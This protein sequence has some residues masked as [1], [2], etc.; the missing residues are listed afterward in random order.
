MHSIMPGEMWLFL[1]NV[2]HLAIPD[3]GV[4]F[5]K[6]LAGDTPEQP[7]L[8]LWYSFSFSQPPDPEM[9]FLSL[10]FLFT[11]SEIPGGLSRTLSI[12]MAM[13]EN[14]DRGV[15]FPTQIPGIQLLRKIRSLQ[16]IFGNR[17]ELPPSR[18]L[19]RGGSGHGRFPLIP[20]WAYRK[21]RERQ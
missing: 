7:T 12:P 13:V 6:L 5:S 14:S 4:A 16:L 21:A 17:Q 10:H 15:R 3:S 9:E 11:A 1:R 19:A 20:E 18:R 8:I 2:F